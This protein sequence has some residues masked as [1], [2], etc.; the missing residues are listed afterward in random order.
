MKASRIVRIPASL[1]L[2]I[3]L[4]A[5]GDSPTSGDESIGTNPPGGVVVGDPVPAV[6]DMTECKDY[7]TGIPMVSTSPYMD[8]MEYSYVGGNVLYLKHIN[9]AF[10]CCPVVDW[11]IRV[12]GNTITIEEI[13]LEGQCL[14][15][16]LYDIDYE[17][18]NLSAGTYQLVVIEPHRSP[19]DPVLEFTMD[20]VSSPSGRHCVH[21]TSYPWG[22]IW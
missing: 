2:V 18:Q 19:D 11:D 17:I 12:E 8:C 22:F 21:R 10:N 3:C 9:A 16:C 5:C 15:L 6:L 4:A 7:S 20:L 14:C 13:E 1:F